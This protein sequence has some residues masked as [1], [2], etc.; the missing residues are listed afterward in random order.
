MDAA[1]SKFVRY[2][3]VVTVFAVFA[4]LCAWTVA[5][6]EPNAESIEVR[7]SASADDVEETRRG[8]LR[9][10]SGDLELGV[11][12]GRQQLVG[13][14]FVGVE[15]PRGAV[16]SDAWVQFTV[17]EVSGG[18]VSLVLRCFRGVVR[19]RLGC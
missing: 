10:R 19:C 11:D 1:A 6:A 17:D 7:V 5:R 13:L 18:G 2:S 3:V 16:V 4:S 9:T 15:V 14:R 12:R 8:R